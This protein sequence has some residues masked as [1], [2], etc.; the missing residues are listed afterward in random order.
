MAYPRPSPKARASGGLFE[1]GPLSD[2]TAYANKY[3]RIAMERRDGILEVRLHTDGGPFQ[4]GLEAQAEL[5]GAFTDIAADRDNRIVILTGTG[6]YFSGP[7]TDPNHSVYAQAGVVP[8]PS[9]LY[10]THGNARRLIAAMLAIEVPM[11]AAINGPVMRHGELA[12]MCDIV[13]AAEETTFEDSAHF[14]LG[15]HVPGDGINVVL[16]LL[17]GINRARYM[18][19]T[20][21][22]LSSKEA[23]EI[24]LIAEVMPRSELLP[25][26]WQL[27]RQLAQK[28]DLVLRYSRIA[29]IQPLKKLLDEGLGYFLAMEALAT[30]DKHR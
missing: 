9:A 14:H 10:R 16:T 17:M 13:I 3:S 18:M 15:G 24:G 20:G 8:T 30:V 12:L 26:A 29:L 7:R 6:D 23:K 25:R 27:G 19:L 11:I 1:M 28:P 5:V 2:L 22:V 4:W 21:Q